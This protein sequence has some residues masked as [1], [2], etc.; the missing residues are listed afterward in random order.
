[1]PNIIN[2]YHLDEPFGQFS[3][4]FRASIRL[5]GKMW[6]TSEH[7]FQTQKFAGTKQEEEVR[8]ANSPSLAA[9]LGRSRKL[10]LRREWESVKVAIMREAVLSKFTQHD[11]LRE[12]LLGT[13]DAKLVEHTENDDYWGDGG[14]GSGKNMLGIIL[15][16]VRERLRQTTE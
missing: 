5:K 13:G 10:P 6:P 1:M 11:D 7:Y 16:E 14:D 15:M 2:F 12:L 3:N 4:F 9:R 8:K